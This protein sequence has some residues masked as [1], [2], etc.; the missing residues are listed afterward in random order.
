MAKAPVVK[1][2]TNYD[3][4]VLHNPE[5]RPVNESRHRKLRDSLK[6]Y[7]TLPYWPIVV[8][9]NGS[10]KLHV[11][12][13]QHR[14]HFAKALKLPVYYVESSHDF[15]IADI[16]STQAPWAFRDYAE[17]F[18]EAGNEHYI[19][20]FEFSDQH[21][22]PLQVAFTV[23]AGHS[24]WGGDVNKLVRDGRFSVRDRQYANMFA[25]T[26]APVAAMSKNCRNAAFQQACMAACRVPGFDP[27]R[28]VRNASKHTERLESRSKREAYLQDMEEIYNLRHSKKIP[29]KFAAIEA[30][31]KRDPSNRGKAA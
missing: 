21:K 9:R 28:F 18:V 1:S 17:R 2:T 26:Y 25:A 13:G 6:K 29:L 3:M 15:D 12:D 4:F 10:G 22:I 7:G 23:L 11:D 24:A 20:A 30:L 19:E 8:H 27:S 16:N 14:L 5:N 31:S